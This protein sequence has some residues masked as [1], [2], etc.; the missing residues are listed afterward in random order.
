M[1]REDEEYVFQFFSIRKKFL[2]TLGASPT[3]PTI[4][5]LYNP[6]AK[7]FLVLTYSWRQKALHAATE[8]Y[9]LRC[10]GP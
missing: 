6:K 5:T 8:S 9:V 7:Q 2:N 3:L 10:L 1:H 4:P